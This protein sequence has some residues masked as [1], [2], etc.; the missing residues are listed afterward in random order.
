MKNHWI[1]KIESKTN[2][3]VLDEKYCDI[4]KK[5][6]VR[7]RKNGLIKIIIIISV[8]LLY[9]IFDVP[10][11]VVFH[12]YCVIEASKMYV[13]EYIK[14]HYGRNCRLHHYEIIR[15]PD[16]FNRNAVSYVT[17][18]SPQFTSDY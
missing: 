3:T 10:I 1:D 16:I 2:E 13:E 4:D 6:T 14:D 12:N 5:K 18:V 15:H 7:T 9:I 8:I 17:G 11:S